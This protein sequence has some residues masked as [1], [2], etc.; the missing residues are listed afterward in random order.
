[1]LSTA[2]A[3]A[4]TWQHQA[5][6]EG[7]SVNVSGQSLIS[8]GYVDH[9]RGALQESGLPAHR[10]VLEIVEDVLA[11][12]DTDVATA[13]HGLRELGV[14]LAIDDFGTGYSSLS[15]LDALPVDILKIDRSFVSALLPPLTQ[16]PMLTVITSLGQG[17]HLD[18]IAEGIETAHQWQCLTSLG[19]QLGQ[20]FLFSHPITAAEFTTLAATSPLTPRRRATRSIA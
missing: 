8:P 13:I 19:C 20:G 15:R 6:F 14:R 9:V 18:L 12:T 5:H 1:M 10:L 17:L 4:A 16:T 3:Q 2:C 7:M 11:I